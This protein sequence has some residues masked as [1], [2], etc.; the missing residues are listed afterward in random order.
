M[1]KFFREHTDRWIAS[2]IVL[3][4]LIVCFANADGGEIREAVVTDSR[5][6]K[7]TAEWMR[8]IEDDTYISSISIPGT[9]DSAAEYIFPG[10]FLKTQGMSIADQLTNGFRYLDIRLAVES[11]KN[12]DYLGFV[13]NFGKCRARSNVFSEQIRLD[14]VLDQIYAFL[15]AQETGK[16]V[17]LYCAIGDNTI[18][19]RPYSEIVSVA[20]NYIR[21]VGGFEKFAEWGLVR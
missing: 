7:S 16:P 15:K 1:I 14:G 3:A 13:H 4:L 2:L 18:D 6:Y 10:H 8:D 9:H 21:S 20:R 5:H 12:G 11:D 17:E 19:G